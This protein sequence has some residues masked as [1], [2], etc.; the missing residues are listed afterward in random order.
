M[1]S[2]RSSFEDIYRSFPRRCCLHHA[3]NLIFLSWSLLEN[4]VKSGTQTPHR[5]R[6]ASY[7]SYAR[8]RPEAYARLVRRLRAQSHRFARALLSDR[9]FF[10]RSSCEFGNDP[11][12][13]VRKKM[14]SLLA[15]LSRRPCAE[16]IL[17]TSYHDDPCKDYGG[18]VDG[19]TNEFVCSNGTLLGT[20]DTLKCPAGCTSVGVMLLNCKR[21]E[22]VLSAMFPMLPFEL[23]L[24]IVSFVDVNVTNGYSSANEAPPS[25]RVDC[26]CVARAPDVRAAAG[27]ALCAMQASL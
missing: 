22:R 17:R 20:T 23:G 26:G 21:P 6:D 7:E 2:Q 12:H 9:V 3:A 27:E 8:Q 24:F 10:L 14:S 11:A 1:A 4:R 18:T 16:P 19:W 15:V 13:I 5:T 25:A